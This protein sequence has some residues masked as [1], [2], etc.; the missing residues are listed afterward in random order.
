MG[1]KSGGSL[2]TYL[3][4]LSGPK[5]SNALTFSDKDVDLESHYGGGIICGKNRTSGKLSD[6]IDCNF[7]CCLP[8]S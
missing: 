2:R 1:K 5:R 6:N 8:H 3:K 7:G 4:S